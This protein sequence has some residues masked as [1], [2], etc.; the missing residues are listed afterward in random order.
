M[1]NKTGK[2][3]EIVIMKVSKCK[4]HIRKALIFK[5]RCQHRELVK[6]KV[7]I[8]GAMSLLSRLIVKS[9]F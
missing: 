9:M 4:V 1:P 8:K 6:D 3:K 7:Y 2:G 5:K